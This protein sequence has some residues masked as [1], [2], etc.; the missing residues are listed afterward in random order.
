MQDSPQNTCQSLFNIEQIKAFLCNYLPV[1]TS[2]KLNKA[3]GFYQQISQRNCIYCKQLELSDSS[4]DMFI[5][6]M[7]IGIDHDDN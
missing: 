2:E 1:N 4:W 7:V 5:Q 3:I 6:R